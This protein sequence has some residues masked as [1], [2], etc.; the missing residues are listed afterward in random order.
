[1]NC[2]DVRTRLDPPDHKVDDSLP[3]EI[4]AHIED[5]A[6]CRHFRERLGAVRD[7]SSAL[8]REIQ[9][10][11]DLWPAIEGRL[12]ETEKPRVRSIS[13][14][15]PLAAAAAIA[16]IVIT[17]LFALPLRDDSTVTPN[18]VR[19]AETA[20]TPVSMPIASV[21]VGF[22]QT[23]SFLVKMLETRKNTMEPEQVAVLEHTLSTI[24]SAIQDIHAAL[25]LDPYNSSL[26]F[27]LSHARRRELQYLQQAI[28]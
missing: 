24:D 10:L 9:P 19:V 12:D 6:D 16:A 20:A 23:R 25:E 8:A 27:K 26:L 15:L 4:L 11:R 28:S 21:E 1:M 3:P 7:P 17:S 13:N 18:P 5:C 2:H 14:F 22:V